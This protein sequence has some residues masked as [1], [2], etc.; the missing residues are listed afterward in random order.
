MCSRD[1]AIDYNS[2]V[3]KIMQTMKSKDKAANMRFLK[4]CNKANTCLHVRL[5]NKIQ[6]PNS[7]RY[8]TSMSRLIETHHADA[9][10]TA[11]RPAFCPNDLQVSSGEP[12]SLAAVRAAA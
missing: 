2:S 6:V 8:D 3:R 12:L 11:F 9:S 5:A 7:N 10:L 1:N 4:I